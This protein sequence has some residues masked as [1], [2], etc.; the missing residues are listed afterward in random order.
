MSRFT[1]CQRSDGR[2]L[3]LAAPAVVLAGSPTRGVRGPSFSRVLGGLLVEWI[4]CQSRTAR[5]GVVQHTG[6]CASV[7]R[8]PHRM[9]HAASRMQEKLQEDLSAIQEEHRAMPR[10][11]KAASAHRR[12]SAARMTPAA[13][14][15]PPRSASRPR[16][17]AEAVAPPR[18]SVGVPTRSVTPPLFPPQKTASAAASAAAAAWLGGA[19]R[20]APAAA[21]AM[22]QASDLLGGAAAPASA[23]SAGVAAF[24]SLP[25][26][27]APAS[28][29]GGL[30]GGTAPK[31]AMAAKLSAGPAGGADSARARAA[32][33]ALQRTRMPPPMTRPGHAVHAVLHAVVCVCG[34]RCC[35][36]VL[37]FAPAAAR[38]P[39]QSGG[40]VRASGAGPGTAAVIHLDVPF[41]P[42]AAAAP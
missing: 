30:F 40:M 1:S 20:T 22:I 17:D 41:K 23:A 19:G 8:V 33:A 35:L 14:P 3:L 7:L 10:S 18:L 21:P 13:P 34:V 32:Q 42:Q 15:P 16:P 5:P 37:C 24:G 12:S 4:W 31:P 27:A 25:G 28:G 29:G 9:P 11:A 38:C 36:A 39:G 26:A 6:V 2:A